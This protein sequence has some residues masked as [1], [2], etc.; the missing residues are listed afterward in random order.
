MKEITTDREALLKIQKGVNKLCDTVA[1]TMGPAGSQVILERLAGG[2]H[3]TRDGVTV[4]REIVLEDPLENIGAMVIKEAANKTA[5]S[6]GDGTSASSV[7]AQAIFNGGLE[8]VLGGANRIDVKR[9]IDLATKMVVEEIKKMA[10]PVEK[11]DLYRIAKISSNGDE[12]IARLINESVGVVGKDGIVT[13]EE[14]KGVDSYTKK[15]EGLRFDRGYLSPYFV[16]NQEKMECEFRNCEV[17]LYDGKIE[18]IKE[19]LPLLDKIRKRDQTAG[20]QYPLLIIAE[21]IVGDA[22]GTLALNHIQQRMSLCAVQSPDHGDSRKE[23]LRDIAAVTGATIIAKE[24]GVSLKSA[25][26]DVLGQA[27][28]IR[29]TQWNTTI[30]EGKGNPDEIF[31]RISTIKEQMNDANDYA[32]V[33][34]KER[35]ARLTSGMVSIHVGGIS[36]IEIKDKK[37]RIDDALC[38]T[39]A[40]LEE[41]V[42]I[43]GG[44]AYLRAYQKLESVSLEDPVQDVG[45]QILLKSLVSPFKNIVENA[46]GNDSKKILDN[47]MGY[48]DE[49]FGYNAKELRF[50]N[51]IEAGVI[52]PAK[53]TR[54]ALENAASVAGMLLSTKAV[55]S[56][57]KPK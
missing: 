25:T 38:A 29:V 30:M 11:D 55:I 24:T 33:K 35:Y 23:T 5:T 57:I 20:L 40:A 19:L 41:G 4:S 37:D 49:N 13:V 51:L 39:K 42:I 1:I 47:A 36:D 3:S 32:L 12:E 45:R 16:T 22:L 10:K 2:Q 9:G 26:P 28:K 8:S 48:M 54:L 14:S 17:L 15:V 53:V 21:D 44:M 50:E 31:G 6:V 18:S 27:E 46:T 34:L 43:G 52:D 56:N 7:L